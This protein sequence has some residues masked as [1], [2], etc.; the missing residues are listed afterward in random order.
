MRQESIRK[1]HPSIWKMNAA[2]DLTITILS[3]GRDHGTADFLEVSSAVAV[4]EEQHA[5]EPAIRLIN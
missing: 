4:I 5:S 3:K 2:Q 1:Q